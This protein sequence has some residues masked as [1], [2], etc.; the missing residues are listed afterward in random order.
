MFRM[1]AH[2]T[3]WTSCFQNSLGQAHTGPITL[4]KLTTSM[5]VSG[6]IHLPAGGKEAQIISGTF[7]VSAW[8]TV[9]RLTQWPLLIVI[10]CIYSGSTIDISH[11]FKCCLYLRVGCFCVSVWEALESI[12]HRHTPCLELHLLNRTDATLQCLHFR[13]LAVLAWL[14]LVGNHSR[15]P[16]NRPLVG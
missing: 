6:G 13:C 14:W 5:L 3:A 16:K 15:A 12:C 10:H 2:S 4:M 11:A 9:S 1:A 8:C 7:I